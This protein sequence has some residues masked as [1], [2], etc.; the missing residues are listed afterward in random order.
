MSLAVCD[1]QG[2][3]RGKRK[4]RRERIRTSVPALTISKMTSDS[5]RAARSEKREK[6]GGK[7]RER[8]VRTHPSSEDHDRRRS[9]LE[10][11]VLPLELIRTC[12]HLRGATKAKGNVS[13]QFGLPFSTWRGGGEG[14]G[15]ARE[16]EG[17]YVLELEGSRRSGRRIQV[18]VLTTCPR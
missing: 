8:G 12:L 4:V 14:R 1:W 10:D 5:C 18:S 6:R 7:K 15:N 17:T 16:R 13:R 11:V 3:R 2:G 9:P